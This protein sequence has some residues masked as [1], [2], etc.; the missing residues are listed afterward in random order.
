MARWFD[1]RIRLNKASGFW[2][3]S[4]RYPCSFVLLF[5]YS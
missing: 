2:N 1:S 4:T 5:F 3:T